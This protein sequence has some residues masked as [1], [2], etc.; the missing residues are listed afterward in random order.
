MYELYTK[1]LNF[2]VPIWNILKVI[3]VYRKTIHCHINRLNEK[4]KTI[5]ADGAIGTYYAYENV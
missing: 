3:R 1:L 4:S 2:N 5:K